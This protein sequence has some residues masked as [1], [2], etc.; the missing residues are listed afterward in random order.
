MTYTS[1]RKKKREV[2][3]S[4]MR[5]SNGGTDIKVITALAA[6]NEINICI[7]H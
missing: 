4:E 7:T 3:L 2:D 6:L 1:V 5:I